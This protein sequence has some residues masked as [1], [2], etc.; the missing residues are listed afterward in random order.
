MNVEVLGDDVVYGGFFKK[1]AMWTPVGLGYR[2]AKR[3]QKTARKPVRKAVSYLGAEE[4]DGWLANI[5]KGVGK[6][7][8]KA[9]KG[10]RAVVKSPAGR[11]VGSALLV[12]V[13]NRMNP[14]Q[15]AQLAQAQEAVGMT[16]QIVTGS[17]TEI[18]VPLAKQGGIMSNPVVLVGGAVAAVAILAL[19][20]KKR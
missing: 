17:N 19:V 8:G 16:P 18:A 10:I 6:Y 13:G 7:G 14:T 12:G 20:L 1:A 3:V 4:L 11:D 9:I 2:A 15:K 5:A